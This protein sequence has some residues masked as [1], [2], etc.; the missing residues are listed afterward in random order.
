[1]NNILKTDNLAWASIY[2]PL[3]VNELNH[4]CLDIIRLYRINPYL[5]FEKTEHITHNKYHFVGKNISQIPHFAFSVFLDIKQ[6]E[7][8]YEIS[9]SNGI[10]SN[11]ILT[12][13]ASESSNDLVKS[14]LTISDVYQPDQAKENMSSVD[15]S[16]ITWMEE[17]QKYLLSW[18]KWSKYR[19]W[20]W[21]M[22]RIWQPMKPSGRR[23]TYMLLWISAAE[24]AL[25]ALGVGIYFLEY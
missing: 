20:R 7:Q 10:K 11:T 23:I 12:I 15:K 13:E 14:K 9:Y 21:Y 6:T 4:F 24:I 18:K 1:M 16:L 22:K 19:L 3:D 8:G 17:I 5:E 2:T 25:I